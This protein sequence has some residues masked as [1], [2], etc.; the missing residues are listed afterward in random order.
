MTSLALRLPHVRRRRPS[1]LLVGCALSV[2]M[3]ATATG[4]VAAATARYVWFGVV[5][6]WDALGLNDGLIRFRK[7]W[8]AWRLGL[9]VP[10]EGMLAVFCVIQ[11]V[12]WMVQIGVYLVM[13]ISGP[14]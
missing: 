13:F 1:G 12:G 4:L 7:V 14:L 6:P 9:R 11:G 8:R 2:L 3:G 10:D 5:L